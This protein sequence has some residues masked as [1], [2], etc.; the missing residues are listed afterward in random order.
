MLN[1]IFLT[2]KELWLRLKVQLTAK[3]QTV[4]KDVYRATCFLVTPYYVVN[5]IVVYNLRKINDLKKTMKR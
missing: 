3:A 1:E 5:E 2:S 4:G